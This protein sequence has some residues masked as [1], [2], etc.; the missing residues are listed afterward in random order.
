MD[1]STQLSLRIFFVFTITGVCFANSWYLF[2]QSGDTTQRGI[3][4][5]L[6][7]ATD[8]INKYFLLHLDH[9][10][11]MMIFCSFLVDLMTFISFYYWARYSSTWR[12][13]MALGIF[14]SFR[15]FTTNVATFEIPQ[16]YNWGYPGIMSVFVPYGSTADFFYSG[17]VGTCVLQ[18]NEHHANKRTYLAAFCMLTMF[19]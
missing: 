4:D 16:G 8:S 12:F 17:H 1:P 19:C 18:Y 9:R 10:N 14:Y 5:S 7:L 6:L 3:K 13:L 15:S 2:Y 11:Y